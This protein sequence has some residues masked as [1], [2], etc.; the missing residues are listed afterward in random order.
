[1]E[2]STYD[3]QIFAEG[4]GEVLPVL[5]DDLRET[6]YVATEECD[7]EFDVKE[8]DWMVKLT[9]KVRNELLRMLVEE[10]KNEIVE[11]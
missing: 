1:M 8:V 3:A 6:R 10:R 4:M 11:Y 9:A 7:F 2:G 5:P